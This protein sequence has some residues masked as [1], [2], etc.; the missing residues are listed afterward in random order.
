MKQHPL[1]KTIFSQGPPQIYCESA[2]RE[3]V[4]LYDGK[5]SGSVSNHS[6]GDQGHVA[7]PPK[8]EV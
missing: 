3:Y 4:T 7:G 2:V 1:I 8:L 6:T 5:D